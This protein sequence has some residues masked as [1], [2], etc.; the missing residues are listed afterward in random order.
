MCQKWSGTI[1]SLYDFAGIQE[2]D[3][4]IES[5]GEITFRVPNLR[6]FFDIYNA[7]SKDSYRNDNNNYKDLKKIEWLNAHISK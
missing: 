2:T 7:S 3:L 6:Q 1:N 4:K 5:Y